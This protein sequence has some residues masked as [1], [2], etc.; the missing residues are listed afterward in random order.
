MQF[1][2]K[3][4]RR[5]IV[6]ALIAMMTV[7]S[8]GSTLA[9][10]DTQTTNA[11][12][13]SVSIQTENV[14]NTSEENVRPQQG[15]DN[16]SDKIIDNRDN[17][18]NGEGYDSSTEENVNSNVDENKTYRSN[19]NPE[20]VKENKN[21]IESEDLSLAA[22]KSSNFEGFVFEDGRWYFYS[23]GERKKGWIDYNG[24]KYYILKDYQLPQNMWRMIKGYKYYFNKDGVM[25]RD[26][27]ISIG[28]T[29]YQFDKNGHQI[30]VNNSKKL[31]EVTKEQS[32]IYA[33]GA[34]NLKNSISNKRVGIIKE[35]GKW[36]KYVD[37]KKT[38]G[39]YQE[40][41]KT[42][43]FL[44]TYNR[45]ENMW[46]KIKGKLYYFGSDGARYENTIRYIGSDTYKFNADGSLDENA[47]PTTI[48]KNTSIREKADNKSKIIWSLKAGNGV[49][50]L[51]RSGDYV[52]VSTSDSAIT[53]WIPSSSISVTRREKVSR[54]ISVAKSKLGSPYVWGATGPTTFDC[55]GFIQYAFRNGAGI[56]LPRVSKN[57][58]TVG[59]Y[60]SRDELKPGDLIFW[61]SPIHH[62]ALYLGDG[63]YI[64]APEPGDYVRI[65]RLGG[66]TTARRIIE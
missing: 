9:M 2:R 12:S 41:G 52:Q 20:N 61:G 56:N 27:K 50:I 60:V 7:S 37:G 10:A 3:L 8:F 47:N 4:K 6:V 16:T 25:I 64:H 15:N 48:S 57:Q 13:N 19:V 24:V 59:R 39:W 23:N 14:N 62:V 63:K 28:G 35:D 26:Q 46:R 30:A 51:R 29:V 42:Y 58:A 53:G 18:Y 55:S 32:N 54:I 17:G 44:N 22:K 11:N 49:N 43:Y 21:D 31:G 34:E 66:Y 5:Q 65:A 36:Y 40:N 45:A 1:K 33:K 38:R